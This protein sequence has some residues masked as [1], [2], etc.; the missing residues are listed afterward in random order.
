MKDKTF[1]FHDFEAELTGAPKG[2]RLCALHMTL[3]NIP[4]EFIAEYLAVPEEQINK[5]Y[6][7]LMNNE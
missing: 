7:E 3:R 1:T 6:R 2:A 5:I 4:R